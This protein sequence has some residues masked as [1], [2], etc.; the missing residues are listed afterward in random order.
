MEVKEA[1]MDE[2]DEDA[3]AVVN[4]EGEE[5][6]DAVAVV[7]VA[8]EEDEVED[9]CDSSCS[10]CSCCH[11]A[12]CRRWSRQDCRCRCGVDAAP[13]RVGAESWEDARGSTTA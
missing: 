9:S 1:A 13:S 2:A 12:H 8:G 10:S 3:V 6:E 4:A 5:D 7:S 11:S